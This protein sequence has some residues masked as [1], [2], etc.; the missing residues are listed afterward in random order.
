VV[1]TAGVRTQR[2]RD[3]DPEFVGSDGV[4]RGLLSCP[5][6]ASELDLFCALHYVAAGHALKRRQVREL[7]LVGLERRRIDEQP[8]VI[9]PASALQ[10]QRDQVPE[11][12]PRQIILRWE[13]AVVALWRS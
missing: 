4:H 3:K 8:C 10:R 2:R 5:Q 6:R 7:I 12:A 9:R 11:A 13:E 1:E